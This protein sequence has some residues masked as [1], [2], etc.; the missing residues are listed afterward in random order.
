VLCATQPT[1]KCVRWFVRR[2]Q[3]LCGLVV[4]LNSG[5]HRIGS[6]FHRCGISAEMSFH[7]VPFRAYAP[8]MVA[9]SK[10]TVGR[11]FDGS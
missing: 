2:R 11:I 6:H 7:A 9:G 3:R 4:P 10:G 8:G 5:Q 1:E